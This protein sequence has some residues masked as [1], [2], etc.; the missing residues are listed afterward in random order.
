MRTGNREAAVTV[1]VVCSRARCDRLTADRSDLVTK[2]Q[3]L[4]KYFDALLNSDWDAITQPWNQSVVEL[5]A[6]VTHET[7]AYIRSCLRVSA[8]RRAAAF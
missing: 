6:S 7:P 1:S 4:T 3:S 2:R 8:T 5:A